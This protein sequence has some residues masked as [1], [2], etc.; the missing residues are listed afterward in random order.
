MAKEK[1]IIEENKILK[2]LLKETLY[3]MCSFR[4]EKGYCADCKDA[5]YCSAKKT[6]PKVEKVLNIKH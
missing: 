6:I 2:E 3:S 5:L 4:S 1:D